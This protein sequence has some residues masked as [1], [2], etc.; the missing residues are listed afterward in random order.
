MFL[1]SVVFR[2][3]I[4]LSDCFFSEKSLGL[5]LSRLIRTP[6]KRRYFRASAE[7]VIVRAVSAK[8][9]KK[10]ATEKISVAFFDFVAKT[11]LKF[12]R[13]LFKCTDTKFA[14]SQIKHIF[15]LLCSEG[16]LPFPASG[17]PTARFAVA[18]VNDGIFGFATDF[19]LRLCRVLLPRT[20]ANKKDR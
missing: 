14:K 13:F 19:V 16:S 11:W 1:L 18:N 3:C 9:D 12:K 2:R 7:F 17:S 15:I 8:L 4:F 5:C 20:S 6:P 10:T